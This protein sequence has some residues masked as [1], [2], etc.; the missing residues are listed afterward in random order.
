[1]YSCIEL[2]TCMTHCNNLI[3]FRSEI[4]VL[5]AH[6]F[7]LVS[8]GQMKSIRK[9]RICNTEW[10][11]ITK[12]Y[13]LMVDLCTEMIEGQSDSLPGAAEGSG[14]RAWCRGPTEHR[15]G[16]YGRVWK[17]EWA[18]WASWR[19]DWPLTNSF[20]T[21]DSTGTW[22]SGRPSGHSKL[23]GAARLRLLPLWTLNYSIW[24]IFNIYVTSITFIFFLI[25]RHSWK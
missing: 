9:K 3:I 18:S 1:M 13:E 16:K 24:F 20:T 6:E 8:F 19:T 23:N 2:W 10:K 12:S 17:W 5:K 21:Q 25:Q 7:I 14:W 22:S 4:R 11:P 15:W